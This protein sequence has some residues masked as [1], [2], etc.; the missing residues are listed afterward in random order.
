MICSL[1]GF[2]AY[3]IKRF[4]HLLWSR[5]DG[6]VL[7]QVHPSNRAADVDVKLSRPGD[8]VAFRPGAAMEHIVTANNFGIGVGKKRESVAH[9]LRMP[10]VDLFRIDADG[11]NLDAA[12][13]EL[14]QMPLKTPQLGVT[15]RSP[16]SAVENDHRAIG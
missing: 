12:R 13:L 8:V 2:T 9:L 15:K 3:F 11:R 7:G 14:R 1:C 4:Q 5:A 6:N 10:A 16:M